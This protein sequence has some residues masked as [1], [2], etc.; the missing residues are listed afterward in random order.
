MPERISDDYDDPALEGEW[1]SQQRQNVLDYLTKEEVSNGNDLESQWCLAPYVALWLGSIP[2][3]TSSVWVISG[4]LPTDYLVVQHECI[5]RDAMYAFAARWKDAALLMLDG[6]TS[7]GFVIGDPTDVA[8][9][10]N[11]GDLLIRRARLLKEFA[12]DESNW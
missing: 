4:D 5:A 8:N 10:K 1:L 7:P 6:K 9:Q 3:S 11:L 2:D 12:E